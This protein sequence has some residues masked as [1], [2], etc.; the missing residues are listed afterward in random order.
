MELQAVLLQALTKNWPT[1][2]L[3]LENNNR[4][5]PGSMNFVLPGTQPDLTLFISYL[6]TCEVDLFENLEIM[7]QILF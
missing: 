4:G 2:L 7:A 5:S 1:H 3:S 6:L